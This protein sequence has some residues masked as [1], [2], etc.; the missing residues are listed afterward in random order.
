MKKVLVTGTPL[1][2]SY[3][4]R[5]KELGFD[6]TNGTSSALQLLNVLDKESNRELTQ[7]ELIELLPNYSIYI[8][9]GLEAA[10]KQALAI[11]KSLELIV[12]MGTGWSEPG[13]VEE[14]AAKERKIRVTNTPHA[15]AASVAE[16]TI[17][18]MICAQRDAFAMNKST[19]AGTW[20]PSRRRD[21]ASGTLGIIGLGH[22]GE[23][24]AQHA[25]L[26][27]GMNVL[28]HSRTRKPSVERDLG[29]EYCELTELL[30][31]S[32]YVSIH[33]PGHL[34]QGLI[35]EL[36]LKLMKRGSILINLSV[37]GIV[38][39]NAILSSI[40]SG[41]I[42]TLVIDGIYKEP[43]ELKNNF[44]ALDDSQLIVLP[45][46]AW[47][48]DDSYTRMS[49]MALKSIEDY[50]DSKIKLMYQVL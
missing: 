33:T 46:T 48:T 47:L 1:S 49:E 12:F 21:I 4:T 19:K 3:V 17:G 29:I 41:H 26:G 30:K 40:Q 18:L 13:C 36:E 10:D 11:A 24:V 5:L 31:R 15:N 50:C 23:K 7:I 38:D 45:R 37:P 32:D 9:G 42:K 28:Y 2:E 27:F 39:G 43:K 44:L 16:L 6:V 34:T 14:S 8:Y 35:S 25:K 22:I 20:T